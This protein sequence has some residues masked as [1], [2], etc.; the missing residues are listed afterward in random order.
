[1]THLT[2]DAC[3]APVLVRVNSDRFVS[4]LDPEEEE[5]EDGCV[6]LGLLSAMVV[7]LLLAIVGAGAWRLFHLLA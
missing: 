5:A 7:Y 1:M 2:A 6:V 3:P 4:R